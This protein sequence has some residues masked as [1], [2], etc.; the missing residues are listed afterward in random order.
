MKDWHDAVKEPMTFSECMLGLHAHQ[1]TA[2]PSLRM[3][4]NVGE[5]TTDRTG[6]GTLVDVGIEIH[7]TILC[8]SKRH[9]S[10]Y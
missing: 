4:K 5:R 6:W 2:R 8:I 9:Y 10:D 3:N 7:K 1:Q